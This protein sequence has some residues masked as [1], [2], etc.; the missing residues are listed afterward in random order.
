M[1]KKQGILTMDNTD[2]LKKYNRCIYEYTNAAGAFEVSEDDNDDM[3][4]A[5]PA[6]GPGSQMDAGGEGGDPGMGGGMPG[7]PGAGAEGSMGSPSDSM[8]GDANGAGAQMDGSSAPQGVDGF[9]PQTQDGNAEGME[10]MGGE[11]TGDKSASSDEEVIDVDDLT[12]SQEKAEEKIDRMNDKFEDLMKAMNVLIKQNAERDA[13]E[14]EMAERIAAEIDRRIP[15][16]Q[17]KMTMRSLKSAP[18]N[19]TP[20]EYMKN[21]APENYSG[22]DDRNGENDSQYKITKGDIDRFTDYASIARDL[23]IAHQG[24]NDILNFRG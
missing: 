9:D 15:T 18:Y 24:L 14:K 21:Y 23:D 5:G 12:K 13:K 6:D 2:Y 8:G 20:D 7:A 1:T 11:N 16:P 19:M 17:Q 10:G 3:A 4:M 22:E